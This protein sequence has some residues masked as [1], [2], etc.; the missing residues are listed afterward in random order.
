MLASVPY[1]HVRMQAH[2]ISKSNF[3]CKSYIMPKKKKSR[4]IL[5][6]FNMEINNFDVILVVL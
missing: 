4:S 1:G 6:D 5:D 2:L 3:L